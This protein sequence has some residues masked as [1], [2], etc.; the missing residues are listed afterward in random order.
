MARHFVEAITTP[1]LSTRQ[2][3]SS[4]AAHETGR[5]SRFL[6]VPLTLADAFCQPPAPP[7]LQAKLESPLHS[8]AQVSTQVKARWPPPDSALTAPTRMGEDVKG[9][10]GVAQFWVRTYVLTLTL[11]GLQANSVEDPLLISGV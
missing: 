9:G 3:R 2:V 7:P 4:A 10:R 11:Q 5:T 1:S 6:R 8:L